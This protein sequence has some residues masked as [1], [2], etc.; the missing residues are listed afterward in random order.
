MSQTIEITYGN[1]KC[2]E[3]FRG[4]MHE[5]TFA[6]F[7]CYAKANMFSVYGIVTC[8]Y[9]AS[10]FIFHGNNMSLYNDITKKY[11]VTYGDD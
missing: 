7:D 1:I 6:S 5:I 4:E 8:Q 3:C 9:C 11:D 10:K 2:P